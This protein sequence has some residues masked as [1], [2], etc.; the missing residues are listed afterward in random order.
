M[1]VL[2]PRFKLWLS[3]PGAEGAFGDG[4]WRLLAALKQEGSLHA[5]SRELHISYRKAWGD[6][7]KMERCLGVR[8]VTKRRGGALG[9]ATSLTA[10]GHRWVEAYT[11]FREAVDAAV[12]TAFGRHL[13]ALA[14]TD[15]QARESATD[16]N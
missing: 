7:Q 4:K 8:L 10:E 1:P 5:A 14:E 16:G 2:H 6:L 3:A 9:G 15:R 11:A 13:K 12:A